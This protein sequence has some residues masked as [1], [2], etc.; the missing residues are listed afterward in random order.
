[1]L[2]DV[3][4]PHEFE[5]VRIPNSVLIPLINFTD[6]SIVSKLPRDKPIILHCRS[7]VRSATS[8]EIL[9]AAGF[10]DVVH[11]SGGVLAWAQQIDTTCEVY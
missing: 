9:K 11:V 1:M 3:R 10:S 8:L 5:I 7:G 2:I 4:E 6:G